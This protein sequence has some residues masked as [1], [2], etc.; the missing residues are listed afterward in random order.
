VIRSVL[1]LR[2]AVALLL[3][4]VICACV[5]GCGSS[6]NNAVPD[7]ES[8]KSDSSATAGDLDSAS[9]SI[10]LPEAL[11]LIRS[12]SGQLLCGLMTARSLATEHHALGNEGRRRCKAGVAHGQ[13]VVGGNTTVVRRDPRRVII[14]VDGASGAQRFYVLVRSG[15]GWLVDGVGPAGS[16]LPEPSKAVTTGVGS[17][18]LERFLETTGKRPS[19]SATTVQC[20]PVTSEHLGE[21]VCTAASENSS[22]G[23]DKR[24]VLVQ[25]NTDGFV[26][27][28][29]VKDGAVVSRCCL[30]AE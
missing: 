14:R 25:V 16:D 8:V 29:G 2:A 28:L 12:G 15:A 6:E 11:A 9:G 21:W 19:R 18:R 7:A 26:T 23:P 30:T 13:G 17:S 27:E 10:G 5:F 3:S 4:F 24:T 20:E 1:G 22:L